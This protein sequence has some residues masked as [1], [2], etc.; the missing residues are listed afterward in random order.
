MKF[1]NTPEKRKKLLKKLKIGLL[2]P[3]ACILLAIIFSYVFVFLMI[4]GI[5]FLLG[6]VLFQIFILIFW[7]LNLI[8]MWKWKK[9]LSFF[10]SIILPFLSVIFYFSELYPFLKGRLGRS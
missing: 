2:I 8:V 4:G 10:L 9:R 5:L 1:I 7:I 6:F 3:S